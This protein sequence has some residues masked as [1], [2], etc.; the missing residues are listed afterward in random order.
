MIKKAE[1]GK[2]FAPNELEGRILKEKLKSIRTNPNEFNLEKLGRYLKGLRCAQGW[3]T[4]KLSELSGISSGLINQLENNCC[5]SLP[6][7]SSLTLLAKVFGIKPKKLLQ[8]A[9][10]FPEENSYYENLEVDDWQV[11]LK[12]Q[13][14]D[15][16]LKSNFIDEVINYIKTV[17]VKQQMEE[18]K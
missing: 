4:A 10:Y 15:I 12:S 18:N 13:L 16:G 14:S 17:K 1:K 6:K 8:L 2:S 11:F 5:K 3:S 9:G 7:P